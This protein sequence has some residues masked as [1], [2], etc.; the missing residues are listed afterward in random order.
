MRVDRWLLLVAYCAGCGTG[1]GAAP[2]PPDTPEVGPGPELAKPSL[3]PVAV[4]QRVV[5][6]GRLQP[7]FH[8]ELEGRVPVAV[9]SASGHELG[10][11]QV[12]GEPVRLVRTRPD[13]GSPY[14]H[15]V[16]LWLRDDHAFVELEYDVE[17]VHAAYELVQV[18]RRWRVDVAR[19]VEHA[20][21]SEPLD[22]TT[23]EGLRQGDFWHGQE[24]EGLPPERVP[25]WI[26]KAEP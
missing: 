18:E 5:D 11:V 12:A 10:A 16:H 3:S 23:E 25:R 17:G 26:R 22:D 9:F 19:V 7:Y 6:D 15:V 4:L 14:L 13:D 21:P 20:R 2:T 24:F 8:A 1:G